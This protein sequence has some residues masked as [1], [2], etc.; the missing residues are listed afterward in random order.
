[1]MAGRRA[2]RMDAEGMKWGCTLLGG[3]LLAMASAQVVPVWG[4]G[5]VPGRVTTEAETVRNDHVYNVSVPTVEF[6]PAANPEGKA[7]PTVLVAP[8]GGY[9]C[10]AYVKEGTAIAQWLTTL[11]VNAAVVKYRI[12]GDRAGA[13]MDARQAIKV[14]QAHATEWHVDVEQLGMIGFSAGAHLTASVLAQ[15]AHGLAYAMLIYPAYLSR[16][17]VTLAQEV[18]PQMPTVPTFIAQCGDDRAFVLSSMGYAAWLLKQNRPVAYHLYTRGGHGFGLGK[19]PSEEAGELN[20]SLARWL[21]LQ[22][23]MD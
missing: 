5:E 16:D 13:L 2:E 12:P 21:K 8:G 18:V 10:Q 11:G 14:L 3:M 20:E 19:A 23:K 9:A 6:F 4:E 22:L 17:G 1:M 15:E 7:L